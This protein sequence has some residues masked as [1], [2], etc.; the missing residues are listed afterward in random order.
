MSAA[1]EFLQPGDAVVEVDESTF[2]IVRAG[3]EVTVFHL[4][5]AGGGGFIVP[6]TEGCLADDVEVFTLPG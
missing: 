3:K 5:R 1:S 4:N 6:R 2:S